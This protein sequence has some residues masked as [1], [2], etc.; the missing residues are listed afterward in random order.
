MIRDKQYYIKEGRKYRKVHI[1]EFPSSPAD[2]YWIS[3]MDGSNEHRSL[4]CRVEELIEFDRTLLNVLA[5]RR[6]LL[7]TLISKLYNTGCSTSNY[8]STIMRFLAAK[9][10][11]KDLVGRLVGGAKAWTL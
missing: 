7:T 1:H 10:V 4:I 2:G 8:A 6:D 5:A 9:K 11:D 3:R